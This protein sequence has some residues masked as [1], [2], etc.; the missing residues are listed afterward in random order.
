MKKNIILLL[1]LLCSVSIIHVS[2]ENTQKA[3][4]DDDFVTKVVNSLGNTIKYRHDRLSFIFTNTDLVKGPN[5]N[6]GKFTI[7]ESCVATEQDP[8]NYLSP[9]KVIEI[10]SDGDF[11][12]KCGHKKSK[13]VAEWIN[14]RMPA[15]NGVWN[16][17]SKTEHYAMK[18][19]LT[20]YLRGRVFKTRNVVKVKLNDF[21]IVHGKENGTN[22]FS[23]G[24]NTMENKSMGSI[25][26]QMTINGHQYRLHMQL[27]HDEDSE[28]YTTFT[29]IMPK[30]SN[31]MK[32]ISDNTP[33]GKLCIP[34]THDS[35]TASVASLRNIFGTTAHCQNFTI[36]DQIVDGIR[37][38]DMRI[39]SSLIFGHTFDCSERFDDAIEYMNQHLKKYPS[40][41]FFVMVG[42]DEGGK[43]SPTMIHNYD[44]LINVYKNIFLDDFKPST[45]LGKVRGKIIM[46]KRQ[47]DCPY[48]KLLKFE[49]NTTFTYD[50][51][52]VEDCYKY[53]KT[54]DKCEV[55]RKNLRDAF[56]DENNDKFYITF[57]SIAWH[58]SH[59]T[60]FQK[61]WGAKLVRYPINPMLTEFLYAQSYTNFGAIMLDFYNCHGESPRL[62]ESIISANYKL[63]EEY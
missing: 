19:T 10:N 63:D 6:F 27:G 54:A 30:N 37:F 9:G 38:F 57:A 15:K 50:F 26:C 52:Q 31:W 49:D 7:E 11:V 43:W 17:L 13:E 45:P 42:S 33:I 53:Y 12:F 51:F 58:P 44:S 20:F 14:E 39:K 40:E 47:E 3:S 62:V 35:G 28:I 61:A 60:P 36:P 2:A 56:L 8:Y 5:G 46:I 55:I 41:V 59:K 34:G 18:G 22:Y 23:W 16:E 48:G 32:G 29:Q 21:Y 1:V 25:T 4:K 24:C